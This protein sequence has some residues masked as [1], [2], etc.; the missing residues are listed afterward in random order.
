MT[1]DN[2]MWD[3]GDGRVSI[4]FS[5]PAF[6]ATVC[7]EVHHLDLP[8][9]IQALLRN[10]VADRTRISDTKYR[11]IRNTPLHEFSIFTDMFSYLI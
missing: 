7:H 5:L 4:D 11:E 2:V 3:E 8:M 10:Q 1:R 9:Q 6:F